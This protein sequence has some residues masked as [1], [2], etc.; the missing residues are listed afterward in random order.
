MATPDHH[1]DLPS[2][3]RH[4][5]GRQIGQLFASFNP[6]EREAIS[7]ISFLKTLRT[8]ETM[9]G[10]GEDPQYLGF[11]L[12]GILGMKKVLPDGRAHIIG[13][14]TQADMFGRIF[15]GGSDHSVVALTDAEVFCLQRAPFERILRGNPAMER[16]FLVNVLDELDA[17]RA[18]ILLLGGRRVP[19]RVAAFLLLLIEGKD[20]RSEAGGGAGQSAIVVHVPIR[21]VEL[22]QYLGT[23]PESLSRALHRLESRGVIRIIDPCRFEITDRAALTDIAGQDWPDTGLP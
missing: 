7:R 20:H 22:A 1:L 8:G 5:S 11:V 15:D 14:L 3:L 10:E 21:R 23:R 19:E 2:V 18:S 6:G 16:A 13:L 9:I 4:G 12:D 17:A